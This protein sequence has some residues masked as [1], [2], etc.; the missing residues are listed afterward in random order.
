MGTMSV[1]VLKNG[2]IGRAKKSLGE[3]IHFF[4]EGLLYSSPGLL[5]LSNYLYSNSLFF[6]CNSWKKHKCKFLRRKLS[7]KILYENR[8]FLSLKLKSI[9]F[10]LNYSKFINQHTPS[11]H[12]K[13]IANINSNSI[14][15]KFLKFIMDGKKNI[16]SE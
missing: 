3:N 5:A 10:N 7:F 16:Y 2:K 15:Y 1:L 6:F 14:H 13:G 11:Y 12:P 9:W 8:L 4:F